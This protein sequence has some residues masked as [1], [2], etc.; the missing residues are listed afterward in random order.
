MRYILP[1]FLLLTTSLHAFNFPDVDTTEIG[2]TVFAG[3]ENFRGIPDGNTNDNFGIHTGIE[4]ASPVPY[5]NRYEMGFQLGASYGVYD[6]A[7]HRQT[8]KCSRNAQT[9]EF[10]TMGLFLRPLSSLPLSMGIVYD[11]MFNQNYG[12]YVQ[13]ITIE[14]LRGQIAYLFT[15]NDQIGAWATYDT[16]RGIKCQRI[17][18]LGFQIT[19]RAIAQVN[20]FWRRFYGN[21][22]ESTVWLG[23]PLRNRLNRE[24]SSLPGKYIIGLQL[25]VPFFENWALTGRACYMQPGT[26]SGHL[27]AREYVSNITINLNYFF[28]GNPTTTENCAWL[29]YLSMANNT[30]FFVDAKTKYKHRHK[31]IS[32]FH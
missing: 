24:H 17:K 8:Y 19:Y 32:Y 9:Q 21:G 30:N 14:Q 12:L 13:N 10:I 31:P 29:P 15:P 6:F 5:L 7:G 28:G 11:W 20:I 18:E 27:G 2:V 3:A 16:S 4:I 23:T 26:R 25:H 22:I 1:F